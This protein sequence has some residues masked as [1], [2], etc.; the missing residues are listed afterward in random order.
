MSSNDALTGLPARPVLW[1]NPPKGRV[2]AFAP[3][4]DDE[5][6]GPGGILARHV[7]Q[8]DSVRVIVSTDG[9]NGDPDGLDARTEIAT[10]RQRESRAGLAILGIDDAHYWGIP[11]GHQPSDVDLDN[12]VAMAVAAIRDYA[13]SIIYLP[14]QQDGHP[15]HHALYVV[16]TRALDQ[17]DGD[18]LALGYEVW[19]AMIPDV[20][21]ETTLTAELKR[22]AM[23]AHASQ[24][25]YVQFDLCLSGL[26][27]YRSMVHLHGRGHGEA[28]CLIRGTL[29]AELA[30]PNA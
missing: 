11:D 6:A 12:G 8:G 29:P 15:D 2:L 9:S 24:I 3:H 10:T 14:W 23:L 7:Q 22:R 18:Y 5:V 21:V 17:L 20:I 4:P 16:V 30:D 1:R 19:N 27:A 26:S 13:P 25:Q 28:L